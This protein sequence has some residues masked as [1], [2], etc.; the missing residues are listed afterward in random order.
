MIEQGSDQAPIKPKRETYGKR[1]KRKVAYLAADIAALERLV[2]K[3]LNHLEH[4]IG[5]DITEFDRIRYRA[6][7]SDI[8]GALAEEAS[9]PPAQD[10]GAAD[11]PCP[12]SCDESPR[13]KGRSTLQ[14]TPM[15]MGRD[16][17]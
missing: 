4:A 10:G 16:A 14:D 5:P 7:V 12:A 9:G 6:M 15:S 1:M 17:F 2:G 13:V 3:L 8:R 11:G